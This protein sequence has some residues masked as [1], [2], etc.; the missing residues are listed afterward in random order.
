[1]RQEGQHSSN[2]RNRYTHAH[3]GL[4]SFMLMCHPPL[5]VKIIRFLRSSNFRNR[6]THAHSGLSSFM[7]MCHPPST[8]KNN[9][10][11]PFFE[12]SKSLHTCA[13]RTIVLHAYVSPPS[14]CK[15]NTIS[16]FFELSKSL[17]TCA[18]RT[19]VLHAYVCLSVK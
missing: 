19:I 2:F 1:M 15:N 3:S 10:I 8:C 16:P 11:S 6:F 7:L 12:L 13:F 17:H 9:T 14:T 4:S 5:P 18:F